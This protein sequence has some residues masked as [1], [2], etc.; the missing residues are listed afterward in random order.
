GFALAQQKLDAA[1][2]LHKAGAVS[3]VDLK[4]GE[5]EF[6]NAQ[7]Q[8]AAA[9]AQA[10]ARRRFRT[11][12]MPNNTSTRSSNSGKKQDAAEHPT[13]QGRGLSGIAIRR[14]VFASMVMMGLVVLGLFGFRRLAIDQFLKVDIPVVTV[15]TTY[16]GASAQ[17]IEREVTP[18]GRS[19]QSGG[20][21]EN[22]HICFARRRVAG[23]RRI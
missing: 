8:L 10:A 21:R 7:A 17:S 11:L 9:T 22:H 19:V 23:R 12:S 16:A 1:R 15:Q 14:P 13:I 20:R 5:A 4:A 18:P 6:E 2:T 3:D